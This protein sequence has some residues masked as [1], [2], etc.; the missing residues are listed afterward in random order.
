[1]SRARTII[2]GWLRWL[3]SACFAT[4]DEKNFV[5]SG[6]ALL[7]LE[8]PYA[9]SMKVNVVKRLMVSLTTYISVPN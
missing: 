6:I 8:N 2:N 4:N 3:V 1:M 5:R 7:F 9:R